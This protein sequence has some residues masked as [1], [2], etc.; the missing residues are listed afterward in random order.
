MLQ[1]SPQVQK[2]RTNKTIQ[3][4][5]CKEYWIQP[6]EWPLLCWSKIFSLRLMKLPI[7]VTC[8]LIIKSEGESKHGKHSAS[9][10]YML[11]C[12][13]SRGE[14][15]MVNIFVIQNN[16]FVCLVSFN[17]NICNCLRDFPERYL[18]KWYWE[19]FG[20]CQ[21]RFVSFIPTKKLS[22][23]TELVSTMS[24]INPLDGLKVR[25]WNEWMKYF[26]HFWEK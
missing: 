2:T 19:C 1:L 15:K 12:L 18:R 20:C 16:S 23:S 9:R 7:F 8:W 14:Y 11:H 5:N 25:M 21:T 6:G 13:P 24:Y 26:V 10:C 3:K 22:V 17:M 4:Q